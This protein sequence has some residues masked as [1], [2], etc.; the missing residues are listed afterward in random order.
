REVHALHQT[1]SGYHQL[2]VRRGFKHGGIVTDAENHRSMTTGLLQYGALKITPNQ[3]EFIQ[4][5]SLLSLANQRRR[6]A[7]TSTPRRRGASLSRMPLT[8]L[9]PSVAPKTLAISIPS[10][11]TT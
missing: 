9:W 11:M 2:A 4:W 8:Y 7:L 5:H 1:V 3:C 10:L 6:E